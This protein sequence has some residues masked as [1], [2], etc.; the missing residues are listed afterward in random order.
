MPIGPRV[1]MGGPGRGTMSSHSGPQDWQLS[2]QALP[3]LPLSSSTQDSCLPPAATHGPRTWPQSHSE[4]GVGAGSRERPGSG[5]RPPVSLQGWWGV[6]L[7]GAPESTG[8]RVGGQLQLHPGAPAPP[9]QKR[10]GSHLFPAPACFVEQ[11]AQVCSHRS[12]SCSCTR[13]GRSCLFPAPLRA[14]EG[15]DPQLLQFGRL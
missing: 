3:G 4:V 11:E 2:P 9:P 13:E 5:S 7:P 10:P 6:V 8:C 1:A 15:S 14:W 12:D